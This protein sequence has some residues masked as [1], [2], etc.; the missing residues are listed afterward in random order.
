MPWTFNHNALKNEYSF[1][2][3]SKL[4]ACYKSIEYRLH[5]TM[6]LLCYKPIEYRLHLK[7][8]HLKI[9]CI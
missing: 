9:G 4:G 2:Y 6:P 1:I 7:M 8:P 5:L 3:K